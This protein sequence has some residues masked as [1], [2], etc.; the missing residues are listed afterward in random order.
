MPFEQTTFAHAI[1]SVLKCD[2]NG[3]EEE[4]EASDEYGSAGTLSDD[5]GGGRETAH[6]GSV[7]AGG[8][9]TYYSVPGAWAG[10]TSASVSESSFPSVDPHDAYLDPEVYGGPED[11]S[12]YYS[13]SDGSSDHSE[14]VTEDED[15]DP[16]RDGGQSPVPNAQPTPYC[17][18]CNREFNTVNGL[19][20]HHRMSRL[21]PWYCSECRVDFDREGDLQVSFLSLIS[22][23]AHVYSCLFSQRHVAA[24]HS[25]ASQPAGRQPSTSEVAD[26]SSRTVINMLGQLNNQMRSILDRTAVPDADTSNSTIRNS[27]GIIPVPEPQQAR[28]LNES[29]PPQSEAASVT[30]A[31]ASGAKPQLVVSCPLCLEDAVALTTTLCGHVFCKEVSPTTF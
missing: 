31:E 10:G 22:K 5:G 27:F 17:Q 4:E 1:H 23:I 15:E 20:L 28:D 19:H 25:D 7:F 8:F 16:E 13:E 21:H 3:S 14:D 24:V 9:N 18:R 30:R 6:Y 29:R 26:T 11:Y 2:C 12:P